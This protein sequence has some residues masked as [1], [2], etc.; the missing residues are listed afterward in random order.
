[1]AIDPVCQMEVDEATALSAVRDGQTFYFCCE[2]CRQKFLSPEFATAG[3]E[4]ASAVVPLVP[5]DAPASSC[6]HGPESARATDAP[7]SVSGAARYI[8]PMC[9]G[10]ASPRPAPCPKCGMALE[11]A[12]PAFQAARAVY[13]CPMHPDVEQ[14]EAGACPICGMALE[15]QYA[16]A[17]PAEDDSELR[18]M[19]WRLWVAAGLG[20]PVFLLAM[21]PMVGVPLDR[22]L[23]RNASPWIQLVLS[24]PVVLWAGWPFFQRGCRSLTTWNLNMFTLIALGTGAAFFYSL[25][26]LLLP[27]FIPADFKKDGHVEVYFEA[28]AMIT[29]LVL[30][31]QVLELRARRRTSSAIRE[32]LSLAPPTARRLSDGREQEVSLGEVRPGDLLRVVPGDKIPVDGQVV[33]GKSTVDESM[34]TGESMPVPKTPADTVIGGTVNQSGSFLMRAERVGGETM[35]AQIV[36][37]VAAAQRSRAPIQRVADTVA[38]WFVP[39]VV[40]VAVVTFVAWPGWPRSSRRWPMRW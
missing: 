21:L 22:W 10:V 30:L 1:M 3:P 34:L 36:Q 9:E 15:P 14:D 28:A 6:C 37:Q 23:P 20:L 27:G 24:A 31:G 38:G 19:T 13:T 25:V 12:V 35:L 39:A 29:A 40:L 11:P 18:D 17:S 7:A 4:Q 26:A 2:H 5:L 32:L 8:C 16:A 33:D